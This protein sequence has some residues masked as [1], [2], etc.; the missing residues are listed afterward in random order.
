[1]E[2]VET[3]AIARIQAGELE[4]FTELYDMY[5]KAI[6]SF[7]ISRVSNRVVAEDLTSDVF[8]RAFQAMPRFDA[9]KASFKT[10][11]YQ[12]ARNRL[13]DHYRTN[14]PADAIEAAAT[15]PSASDV[16]GD[17]ETTLHR[18]H[19]QKLLEQLS[20]ENHELVTMR[21][22][23]ELS[24]KEIAI[25]TGKPEANLKVQF[26]RAVQKLKELSGPAAALLLLL[27][28]NL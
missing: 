11:L 15:V 14:K 1:M 27:T 21:V 4:A 18:E 16:V 2:Q 23:D 10:W 20:P 7:L 26:S 25:I 8:M 28:L 12:I 22:W 17:L 5:V 24:Y 6:F 13:I 19:I 3:Q 9:N